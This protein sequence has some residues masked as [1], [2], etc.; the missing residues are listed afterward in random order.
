MVIMGSGSP[1]DLLILE[2]QSFSC[3]NH[4][5]LHVPAQSLAEYVCSSLQRHIIGYL[6]SNLENYSNYATYSVLDP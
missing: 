3:F 1:M 4:K 6:S 2:L 5:E